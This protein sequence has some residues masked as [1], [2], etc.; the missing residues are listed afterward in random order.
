MKKLSFRSLNCNEMNRKSAAGGY[1]ER[2]SRV[3]AE[4]KRYQENGAEGQPRTSFGAAEARQY[5]TTRV[6]TPPTNQ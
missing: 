1:V 3:S 5:V 6:I 4:D 2:L